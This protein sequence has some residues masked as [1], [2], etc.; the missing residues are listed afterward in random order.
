M[1]D[2]VRSCA[3][4]A[5]KFFQL[6]L[7]GKI[8][9][10][11]LAATLV[12][13]GAITL[14]AYFA[15]R[16]ELTQHTLELLESRAYLER[17]EIELRLSGLYSLA[18]SLAANTVTASTLADPRGREAYL[19]PL[20]RNQKLTVPGAALT[21]ADSR[22]RPAASTGGVSPDYGADESLRIALDQGR[23]A[24]RVVGAEA[25]ARELLVALPIHGHSGGGGEGAVMLRVP[26]DSLLGGGAWVDAR[27]LTDTGGQVLAGQPPVRESF[28]LATAL[29]LPGPIDGL[30]LRLGIAR[31]HAAVFHSL[32]FAL[33]AGFLLIGVVALG[34]VVAFAHVGAGFIARPLGRIAA[35]A[36][37]IAASGR[38]VARLPVGGADEFGRLSAAF[39]TMVDRLRESYVELENRVAERTREY[40]ETQHEAAKASNLLREA[41]QSIAVGFAI[42][43]ENDCLVMC[44]EAYLR[45]NEK[46]RELIVPGAR[47]AD[48]VRRNAERGQYKEAL[49]DIDAWVAQRVA[50]HRN[51][52]GE[53]IEQPLSDGR[54]LLIVEYRTPSGYIVGNFIDITRLNHTSEAL[55]QREFYLRAILDNLPFLFWL[56][57]AENRFLAVNKMFSDACG[58]SGPEEV[59]GLTDFD[60]WPHELARHYRADDLEV[61]ASRREKAV[62]E[63]VAGGSQAGWI[64]TYKRPVIADDGTLLGTVGFAMD[65]SERRFAEG[66]IRDRNAQLNAIFALS[67]DG[68]VSFDASRRVKYANPAFLRMTG[69]TEGEISGLDEDEFS[70]LLARA[71]VDSARFP[72]VA[73]L[74]RTDQKVGA[75]ETVARRQLI[76]LAGAGK[77][78]L[79]VDIRLSEAET[80]SQIL[81]FRDVTHETEV[82]RMKSEFLSTAAHELR[83]PMASIYGFSEL[84]LAYEFSEEERREYLGAIYRQSQLMVA[85]INELLDLARIEARRGKDFNFEPVDLCPL[86]D[87]MAA[88]FP[89][90]TGR[91]WPEIRCDAV[92]CR[93]RADRKKLTQAIGN[94]LSNAYKYSPQGGAVTIEVLPAATG[95]GVR[96]G[97]HGIGMTAEQQERMCERFYRADSSGKIPGTG[98]GMSIVQEIVELH[99]GSLDVASTPGEGTQVTLWIPAA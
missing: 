11:L 34:G 43:D 54:W 32:E 73:A 75:D 91:A 18:E 83:T 5:A 31:D 35:A 61:M 76:E 2:L 86:L 65:I 6:D 39:N 64:E 52:R 97:D 23:V 26:L 72:G 46:I 57:D 59:A 29:G 30:G 90:P 9:A 69:F 66:Q 89:V 40:E 77:R 55:R 74:L 63:P 27:W 33:L 41:V 19:D 85:I 84:M 22:G 95:V 80:V 24:A 94:V 45:L 49:G 92:P 81:Y 25:G 71:C 70:T 56:K 16:H 3:A 1:P 21:V 78:V 20:L 79:E 44:N 68:F 13:G 99:G 15:A 53:M 17:R 48:I 14:A 12:M 28:E 38:P 50:Q 51:A 10:A 37:E 7:R 67:P 82:D 62:V 36:E 87:Q 8:A 4:L 96:I 60:V 88:N 47:F 42:Y 58:R 93:V 98:L